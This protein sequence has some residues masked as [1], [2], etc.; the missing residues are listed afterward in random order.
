MQVNIAGLSAHNATALPFYLTQEKPHTVIVTETHRKLSP[1]E[2]SNYSS[3]SRCGT[4]GQGGV[5]LLIRNDITHVP[6]TLISNHESR[7]TVSTL[8]RIANLIGA[9]YIPPDSAQK[10]PEFVDQLGEPVVLPCKHRFELLLVGDMNARH[11][12]WGD[13]ITNEQERVLMEAS[14]A[15]CGNL[16]VLNHGQPTFI[17]VNENSIINLY[18]VSEKL[19]AISS[20]TTVDQVVELFTGAPARVHLPTWLH[21]KGNEQE[22]DHV[23]KDLEKPNWKEFYRRIERELSNGVFNIR[24]TNAEESWLSLN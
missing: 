12:M 13:K 11:S 16:D 7:W 2:V 24:S 22:E 18:V 21:V 10:L 4:P 8:N 5:A 20:F 1:F 23:V 3:I 19:K 6:Q 14:H 9:V 17:S 15:S